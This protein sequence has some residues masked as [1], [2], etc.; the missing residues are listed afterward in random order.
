MPMQLAAVYQGYPPV[1][2][3]DDRS[4]GMICHLLAILTGFIG[5]LIVWLIKKDTSPFVNHHGREALNF[6]ITVFLLSLILGIPTFALMF[7]GIG[8][9]LLPLLIA[10][11][12]LALVAEI[13]ACTAAHR[14]EW[15]RY[16]FCI[17]I[18]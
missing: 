1:V 18:F 17:R 7:V 9:L 14:G 6:Q 5:P 13:L 15:H 16:P 12:V 2:T 4:M 10:V 3:A 8:F 11:P